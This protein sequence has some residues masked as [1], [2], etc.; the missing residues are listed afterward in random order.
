MQCEK[1]AEKVSSNNRPWPTRSAEAPDD[2]SQV[3]RHKREVR[4]EREAEKNKENGGKTIQ[5]SSVIVSESVS[6]QI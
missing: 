2:L 3:R 5:G 6:E 4:C 1:K